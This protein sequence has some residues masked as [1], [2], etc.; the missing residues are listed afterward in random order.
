MNIYGLTHIPAGGDA[1]IVVPPFAGL[2][3]PSLAAH[4]L[5]ACA[6]EAGLVVHVLYAN[7]LLAAN[8]GEINYEAVC[9]T[10]TGALLGERFFAS[11]AYG[12]PPF[13]R[14]TC[15]YEVFFR[16]LQQKYNDKLKV[17]LEDLRRLEHVAAEWADGLAKAI[18]QCGVGV[19]GVRR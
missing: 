16:R 1:L 19:V 5:Q 2:D 11:A 18:A 8:I 15:D 17:D 10:P 13:G 4:L 7:L 3:R 6:R 12:V 9:Y 14:N